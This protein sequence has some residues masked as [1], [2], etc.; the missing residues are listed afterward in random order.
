[1]L[2]SDHR[3]PGCQRRGG[4]ASENPES[5]GEVARAPDG[6]WT[7]RDPHLLQRRT[8]LWGGIRI[9]GLINGSAVLLLS[10]GVSE[11]MELIDGSIELTVQSARSEGSFL[12]CDSNQ[13]RPM[14][15]DGFGDS[16]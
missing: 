9:A 5:K 10:N 12:V 15:V 3:A 4:I 13:R 11:V 2:D 16:H 7:Q 8:R 6:H 14:C 1:M